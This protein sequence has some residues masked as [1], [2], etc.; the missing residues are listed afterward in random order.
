M[1]KIRDGR[2]SSTVGIWICATIML[3]VALAPLLATVESGDIVPLL[4]E[5][6]FAILLLPFSVVF[7]ASL[8]TIAVW[9]FGKPAVQMLT[10]DELKVLTDR[11]ANL[12]TIVSFEDNDLKG[13]VQRLRS[14]GHSGSQ[15]VSRS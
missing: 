3:A 4:A 10:S 11:L 12:E 13:K 14:L 6:G 8:A 7:G 5:T 15:N 2:V 9:F 1:Q